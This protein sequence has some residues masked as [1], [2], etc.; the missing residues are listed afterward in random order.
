MFLHTSWHALQIWASKTAQ[1]NSML[2]YSEMVFSSYDITSPTPWPLSAVQSRMLDLGSQKNRGLGLREKFFAKVLWKFN[3]APTKTLLLK[4]SVFLFQALSALWCSLPFL[5]LHDA[6]ELVNG[7]CDKWHVWT[8]SSKNEGL[9]IWHL[10][11]FKH[12][13]N[14]YCKLFCTLAKPNLVLCCW[15]T[16]TFP[17]GF[18]TPENWL[19]K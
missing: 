9:G 15:C 13:Q 16:S 7:P 14:I 1:T 8:W 12:L 3:L 2:Q 17:L 6:P 19:W 18:F 4:S 11:C 5:D 10:A